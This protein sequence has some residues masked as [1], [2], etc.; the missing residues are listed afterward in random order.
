[1]QFDQK[2]PK[3]QRP[4]N[5]NGNSPLELKNMK[6]EVPEVDDLISEIDKLLQKTAPLKRSGCRC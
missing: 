4:T 5:G 3:T 1:M 2:K 6:A